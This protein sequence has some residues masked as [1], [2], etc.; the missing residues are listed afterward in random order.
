MA[1]DKPEYIGVFGSED[2]N[3]IRLDEHIDC[4]IDNQ[5]AKYSLH[6]LFNLLRLSTAE[7]LIRPVIGYT[8]AKTQSIKNILYQKHSIILQKV[9]RMVIA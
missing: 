4:D 7:N 3:G 1:W 5:L 8:K 2:N 6:T 9:F